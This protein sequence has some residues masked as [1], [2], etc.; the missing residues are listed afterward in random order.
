MK[1]ELN[2]VW[3][4]SLRRTGMSGGC[5]EVGRR[6]AKAHSPNLASHWDL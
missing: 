3:P 4:I 2:N 1:S 6:V 5:G